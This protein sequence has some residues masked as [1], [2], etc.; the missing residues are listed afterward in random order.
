MGPT[1]ERVSLYLR[2]GRLF[3]RHRARNR[4]KQLQKTRRAFRRVHDLLRLNIFNDK[5]HGRTDTS[6]ENP[7]HNLCCNLTY[8]TKQNTL[9]LVQHAYNVFEFL[10]GKAKTPE[11]DVRPV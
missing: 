1:L 10:V 11:T 7:I 6:V 3:R 5:F 2:M 9:M 4:R 8:L